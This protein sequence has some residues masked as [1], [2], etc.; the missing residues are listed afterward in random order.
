MTNVT[1]PLCQNANCQNA[2]CQMLNVL[3]QD[4]II[5]DVIITKTIMPKHHRSKCYC[6]KML[7][8]LIVRIPKCSNDKMS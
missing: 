2:K 7:K 8:H 4:V 6:A 5:Q 1:M 3:I